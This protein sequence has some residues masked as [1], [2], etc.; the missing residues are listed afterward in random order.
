MRWLLC[1]K[2]LKFRHLNV[3]EDVQ[4]SLK[5]MTGS[6]ALENTIGKIC[7]DINHTS[8]Q[9][10]YYLNFKQIYNKIFDSLLHLRWKKRNSD[11]EKR[12]LDLFHKDECGLDFVKTQPPLESDALSRLVGMNFNFSCQTG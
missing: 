5:V 12:Y 6:S 3:Y 9:E 10:V 2:S 7:S 1:N 8:R 4:Y 11:M